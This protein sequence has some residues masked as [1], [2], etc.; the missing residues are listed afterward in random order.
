MFGAVPHQKRGGPG[1]LGVLTDRTGTGLRPAAL[2]ERDEPRYQ[3]EGSG[4]CRVAQAP[5]PPRGRKGGCV[6]TAV[7]ERGVPGQRVLPES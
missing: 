5:T 4:V 6:L 2:A 1:V 7:T 3:G